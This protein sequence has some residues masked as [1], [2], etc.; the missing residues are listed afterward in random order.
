MT[1]WNEAEFLEN[2]FAN[3]DLPCG[4]NGLINGDA[5]AEKVRGKF[6]RAERLGDVFVRHGLILG[7][8]GEVKDADVKTLLIEA[9]GNDRKIKSVPSDAAVFGLPAKARLVAR[10]RPDVLLAS[11]LDD[12]VRF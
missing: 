6:N 3:L 7:E 4:I 9:I 2:N 5:S 12:H 10:C 8:A 11:R 1:R